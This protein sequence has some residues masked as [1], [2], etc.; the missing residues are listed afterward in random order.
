[1]LR[2]QQRHPNENREV[3]WELRKQPGAVRLA[4]TTAPRRFVIQGIRRRET[5]AHRCLPQAGRW[6]AEGAVSNPRRGCGGG[7]F[8]CEGDR[9]TPKGVRRILACPLRHQPIPRV[10]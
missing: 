10:T 7:I 4:G 9:H 3:R 5:L 6:E 1:M 8:S 2:C